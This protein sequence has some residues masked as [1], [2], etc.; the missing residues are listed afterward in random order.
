M[1]DSGPGVKGTEI[2]ARDFSRLM[3]EAI[4]FFHSGMHDSPPGALHYGEAPPPVCTDARF[5][6]KVFLHIASI[7]YGCASNRNIICSCN[8]CRLRVSRVMWSCVV[9]ST[10]AKVQWNA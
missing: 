10:Q 9:H 8:A 6:S 4:H 3:P 2:P 1:P 7:V 5:P